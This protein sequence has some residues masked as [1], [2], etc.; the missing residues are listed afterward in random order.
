MS[1]V[2]CPMCC[3]LGFYVQCVVADVLY[4]RVLC[5]MCCVRCVVC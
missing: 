3:M 4:V 2:L 1:D 5:P